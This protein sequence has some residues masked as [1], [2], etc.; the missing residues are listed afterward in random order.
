MLAE[1]QS[2]FFE[3]QPKLAPDGHNIQIHLKIDHNQEVDVSL[4]DGRSLA[5]QGLT[6]KS[7]VLLLSA[8]VL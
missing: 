8:E 5:I 4:G 7:S 6:G 3:F 1:F 2:H